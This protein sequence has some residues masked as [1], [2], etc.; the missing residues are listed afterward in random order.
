MTAW[1]V[2]IHSMCPY[3]SNLFALFEKTLHLLIGL[4]KNRT[5]TLN[6]YG[7]SGLLNSDLSISRVNQIPKLL[8]VNFK[9]SDPYRCCQSFFTV[10]WHPSNKDLLKAHLQNTF[11]L[12]SFNWIRLSWPCLPIGKYCRVVALKNVI[13]N[14]FA[15]VLEKESVI[16]WR[17]SHCVICAI[18]ALMKS[19]LLDFLVVWISQSHLL[20]FHLDDWFASFTY[21]F[22]IKRTHSYCDF[23]AVS[24]SPLIPII[25]IIYQSMDMS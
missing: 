17:M 6:E 19:K 24:H 8:V 23:N 25:T 20:T 15:N 1:A 22:V 4:A 14:F 3:N 18:I 9:I 5:D 2:F 7:G 10:L 16:D 11:F 21:L 12:V 13:Q